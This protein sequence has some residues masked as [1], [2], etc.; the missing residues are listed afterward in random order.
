MNNNLFIDN[1]SCFICGKATREFICYKCNREMALFQDKRGMSRFKNIDLYFVAPYY[2]QYKSLLL[3]FKFKK[4]TYLF[5]KISYLMAAYYLNKKKD[6]PEIVIPMPLGKI[7]ERQRGFNQSYLLASG[8]SDVTGS[9]LKVYLNR[10]DC[11][12]LSLDK[13][14]KRSVLIANLMKADSTINIKGKKVLVIDDIYTTGS[15]MRES[16]RVLENYQAKEISYLFFARQEA[17]INLKKW[18]S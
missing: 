9:D 16:L 6:V 2:K 12:Q 1:N 5:K 18:F 10:E 17:Q 4:Q 8:F 14:N 11:K 15:T 7:K 13:S 3:R